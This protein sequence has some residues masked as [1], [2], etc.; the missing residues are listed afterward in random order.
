MNV[1]ETIERLD[2]E[3]TC[4]QC[5]GDGGEPNASNTEDRWY[6]CKCKGAGFIPTHFG[7]KILSLMRHN[8]GPMLRNVTSG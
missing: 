3:V 7:E 4:P 8:F 6:C 2:L 1:V 5:D